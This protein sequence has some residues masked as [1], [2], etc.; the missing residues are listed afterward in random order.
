M[1]IIPS[2]RFIA[3][4]TTKNTN[5]VESCRT[6]AKQTVVVE[7]STKQINHQQQR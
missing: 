1:A 7:K 4:T 2:M 3:L 6:L 5:T